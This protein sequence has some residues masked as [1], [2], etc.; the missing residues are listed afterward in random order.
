MWG[1]NRLGRGRRRSLRRRSWRGLSRW[2]PAWRGWRPSRSTPR[3]LAVAEAA[4]D[5]GAT[6]VNDVTAL[7]H[8]PEIGALCAERG[9]GLVLMHMQGDPRTMQ[10]DPDLRRRRRRRQG[11]SRRADRGGGRRRRRRGADLARP[12]DRLR[13]DPRAQPRAAAPA[14]RAARARA[15]AGRR[16]LAQ[17]LHRQDRRLRRSGDRLG[18][19]IASSVLAAAEGADVLRVHDVAEAAQATRVASGDPRVGFDGM[20][21]PNGNG[22]ESRV[23][24]ELRGLSIYT[25]HGV[26]DAEQE[27]GQRLEF[28][29]SFDVPDCDAVLT[30]RIEDTVDYS[31]VCDIVA[32]AATERS[33]RTLERL[34]QV[35]GQRL[36]ERYG[37][38]SVRV[39]AVEARAAAAAGDPGGR[40]SRSSRSAA[41]RRGRG[42]RR[43]RPQCGPATW[44]WAP[45]SATA[46]RTCGRRS[47]CSASA[48][49]RS[50]R[51]PPPTRPS[52]SARCSTSRTSSTPRSASAPSWS[53]RRCSTSARR[54]RS[55]AAAPLDAPRHSPR[56]LDVDLLLLGDLEL[57]TD[58]LTLP[59]PEVTSRRF[60]LAPLLELDPELTL[61]DGTRLADALVA[62]GSDDGSTARCPT[63]HTPE[64]GECRSR[65]AQPPRTS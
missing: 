62:L 54:S 55:S 44:A 52:R 5:A 27:V 7:R 13:Q 38:E 17:E 25:H 29:I 61:P 26:S 39:R 48:G 6:I 63:V 10:D 35:V 50:R 43:G 45:T 20:D 21:E 8:D 65:M 51:S 37:C 59:H 2:S 32:L 9:A 23:E 1:G 41:K 56:P 46:P 12:R 18:G 64:W 14:R 42:E 60:V 49:W 22:I 4:L 28:D 47:R 16:H 53:R 3:R 33:Y 34:A 15:A 19:T 36:I 58:R 40:A 30:D 31:E 24:V 57:S 11:L